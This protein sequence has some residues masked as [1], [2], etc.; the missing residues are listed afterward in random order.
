MIFLVDD[1]PDSA[2]AFC[3]LL[4][5]AGFPCETAHSGPDALAFIRGYPPEQPLLVLLDDMMPLMS[6]IET[7]RAIRAD[8]RIA[9]TPIIMFSA[10]F[11][12]AK[13]DEAIMLGALAWILKGSA[14]VG[15]MI[16]DVTHHYEMLGGVSTR[17]PVPRE[18]RD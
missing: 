18:E 15:A 13:R 1:Y 17:G 3:K 9:A 7:L 8:P 4:R 5:K 12:G 16:R 6:G 11:D 2:E 10:S 14:D